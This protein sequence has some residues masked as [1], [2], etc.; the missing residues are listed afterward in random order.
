[1]EWIS[2]NQEIFPCGIPKHCEW[3]ELSEIIKVLKKIG[4][5]DNSNHT[6]FPRMGGMDLK[7]AKESL[8][9]NCLELIC[10]TTSILKP[11]KLTFESF[12]NPIWNYFRLE[13]ADM[14]QTDAYEYDL[15]NSEEV[16]ELTPLNYV[17]RGYW[18]EASYED[19]PLPS[20][21][22]LVV[23]RIKGGSYVVFSKTSWYNKH[24][25][26]Y[27]ARHNEMS[28]TEFRH[29]IKKVISEGWDN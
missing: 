24:S 28:E 19:K 17:N 18:D 16:T 26:T 5:F 9:D 29:Y 11:I 4:S 1:M 7:D 6:F 14:E 13:S 8:E 12:V 25:Q 15:E 3:S 20:N 21:A 2:I 27:D 22:R 10:G 23:R